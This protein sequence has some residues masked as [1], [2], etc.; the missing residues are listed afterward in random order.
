MSRSTPEKIFHKKKENLMFDSF[1]GQAKVKEKLAIIIHQGKMTKK[2]P[3]I[4]LFS[5]AG[6]G[7]TTLAALI[8]KELGAEYIYMNGTAIKEPMTFANKIYQAKKT[9]DKHF[10]IF[11]DEA[12]SLPRGIQ[13]NLLSILEEPAILCFVAPT[14]MKCAKRDGTIKDIKRGESIQVALPKNISFLLGTTHRGALQ[15][16]ILNRLIEITFDPYTTE[17]VV[18]IIRAAANQEFPDDIFYKIAQI[19]R[20]IRDAKKYLL[21]LEAFADMHNLITLT[22]AQF[23]E[24][25]S[26]YGVSEDGLNSNDL[27]YLSVLMEHHTVGLNNMSSLLGITAGEITNIVEPYLFQ[28][29]LLAMTPKGRELSQ[30]GHLR[31]GRASDDMMVIEE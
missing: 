13:D 26:I 24:F 21:G 7:K 4:G 25:C 11:I 27:R 23:S 8:A 5:S 18:D 28:K 3:H 22:D 17:E 6:C 29:G 16:T 30:S 2:T 14:K 1:K 9:P 10:I 31:M 19:S 15:D 12:H 20:N